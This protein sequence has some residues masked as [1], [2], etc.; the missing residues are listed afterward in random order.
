[1]YYARLAAW[2]AHTIALSD[3]ADLTPTGLA[4][5]INDFLTALN[6]T[7]VTLIG[8][9]TGGAFSQITVANY[10]ARIGRLVL[11]NCDAFENFLPPL[12]A[13]F[14]WL[15]FLPTFANIM[16]W[17]LRRRFFQR[18][19]FGLTSKKRVE[20]KAI[21]SFAE[22][23][24]Q[25]QGVR[26]DLVKVLRGISKRYTLEAARKFGQFDKPVLIVWGKQ[27][28]FFPVKSARR[29]AQAFPQARLELVDD[30]RTFVSEDQPARLIELLDDFLVRSTAA[31]AH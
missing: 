9:D 17:L 30:S 18:I 26:R 10:P 25:N 16:A 4:Q 8:V 21:D 19:F 14:Q 6:L 15:A 24:G 2:G 1:M 23:L 29:L 3:E 11:T 5:L 12:L 13:P 27:D 7:D 31:I 28:L 20:Q 22:P